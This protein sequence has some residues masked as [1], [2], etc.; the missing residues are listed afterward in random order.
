MDHNWSH[1]VSW[2]TGAFKTQRVTS[3]ATVVTQV[4]EIQKLRSELIPRDCTVRARVRL[5]TGQKPVEL[6]LKAWFHSAMVPVLEPVPILEP[7][8]RSY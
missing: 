1:G 6:V 2:L 5:K 7:P 4:I 8:D 3:T